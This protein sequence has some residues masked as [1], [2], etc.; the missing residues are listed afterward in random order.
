MSE[1]PLSARVIAQAWTTQ[2]AILEE[3]R[4]IRATVE[5]LEWRMDQERHPMAEPPPE[6]DP[7]SPSLRAVAQMPPPPPEQPTET[8]SR[9]DETN[10]QEPSYWPTGGASRR[11]HS[12]E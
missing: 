3:L 2:L 5:R 8:I 4:A 10:P 7:W 1:D 12:R 9:V 11:R 6:Q